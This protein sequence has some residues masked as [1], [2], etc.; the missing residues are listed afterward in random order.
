MTREHVQ[1]VINQY[2]SSFYHY[3]L[4]GFEAHLQSIKRILHP[5]I[6][7]WYATKA[8]PMSMILRVLHKC[9]FGADVASLGELHQVSSAGFGAQDLIATGPAKSRHYLGSLLSAKVDT[10]IIESFNQL[11]DLDELCSKTAIRQNV[12]LRVQLDWDD[13]RK[14]VL[15]GAQITPFGLDPHQWLVMDVLSFKN[16][17]IIGLHCF[18]W[19]NVTQLD[20]LRQIWS[21]TILECK[22]LSKTLGIELQVL[23]L[24][25]G[26]GFSYQDDH[27]LAFAD[28]HDLLLTLKSDH[29]LN[30]IWL[31]LGRFTIGKFGTYLTKIVDL[32]TVRGKKLIVT[33]GGINH[34]ARSAL[35]GESF[36]C[37]ALAEYSGKLVPYSVHGPLCTALDHLGNFELPEDLCVGDWLR[38]KKVGAYGFTESMPYFLC[39]SSAGEAVS[40]QQELYVPRVPTANLEWLL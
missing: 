15:G 11:K 7:V 2:G 27:E 40:Y 39:H 36:P 4:D 34:M 9:G 29:S 20:Q 13:D 8:N 3:D 6:K 38:F 31:E 28:V 37:E 16:V 1:A 30:K 19:G 21:Y 12:L 23:D 26:I 35:V 17:N 14:S 32:K 5:D 10:I 18:Q 24:G 33:E 25:G 22:K